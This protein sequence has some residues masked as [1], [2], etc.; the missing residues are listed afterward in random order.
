MAFSN[1]FKGIGKNMALGGAL[2]VATTIGVSYANKVSPWN[3]KSI[4]S[5]TETKGISQFSGSTIDE[6]VELVMNDPNKLNHIFSDKHNLDP[7]ATSLGGKENTIRAVLN[8]ANGNLPANGIYDIPVNVNGQTVF[9]RGN[10]M[11]GIPRIGT[12][13]IP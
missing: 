12:M 6:A 11:G 1:S 5:K 7:L 2:G 8:A 9:I 3:G 13:Y 4:T 10:V